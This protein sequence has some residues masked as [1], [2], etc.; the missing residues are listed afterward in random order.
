MFEKILNYL[1]AFL[2]EILINIIFGN[3]Y[4]RRKFIFINDLKI[5]LFIDKFN[6]LGKKIIRNEI[7]EK[8]TF[9]IIVANLKDNS[10]FF[11]IGANEGYFSLIASRIN[12]NGFNYLFEPQS[13][14]YNVIK[15]NFSKNNISNYKLIPCALGD[16]NYL[17]KINLFQL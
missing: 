15:K 5:Y 11:D 6:D 17:K 16:N 13:R 14:L 2:Q 1:P 7:Y 8:N 9:D 3:D 4:N 10:V 12:I